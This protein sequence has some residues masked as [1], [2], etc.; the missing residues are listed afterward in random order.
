MAVTQKLR[1]KAQGTRH[2]TKVRE[3]EVSSQTTEDRRQTTKENTFLN[4]NFCL[5]SKLGELSTPREL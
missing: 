1:L 4:P 2:K 5:L 3:P